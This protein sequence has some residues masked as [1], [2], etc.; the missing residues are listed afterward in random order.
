MTIID[1][2]EAAEA[3]KTILRRRRWEEQEMPASVLDG[4]QRIFGERLAPAEA[5]ARI[6][7]SVRERGDAAL[8]EW[9]ARIDGAAA[10]QPL[11]I[12]ASEWQAAYGRLPEAERR[13]LDLAAERID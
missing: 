11:E 6:L 9:S 12:A 13:A 5:V 3:Q 7:A 1:I 2:Y 10:G 8:A 4:I